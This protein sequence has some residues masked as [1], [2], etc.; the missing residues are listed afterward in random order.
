MAGCFSFLCLGSGSLL[1]KASQEMAVRD[2]W[3]PLPSE[4]QMGMVRWFQP[5]RTTQRGAATNISTHEPPS[6]YST[7]ATFQDSA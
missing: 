1:A 3:L 4:R 6:L 2:R 5:V 7:T